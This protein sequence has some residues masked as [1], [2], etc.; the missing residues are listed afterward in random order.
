MQCIKTRYIPA[1]HTKPTRISAESTSGA[2][3]TLSWDYAH[4]ETGNH[5]QACEALRA[6]LGWTKEL[7]HGE[8]V[9]APHKDAWYWVFAYDSSRTTN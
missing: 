2:K 5:R 9:G 4:G 3:V 7:A 1:T 8:M 6:K